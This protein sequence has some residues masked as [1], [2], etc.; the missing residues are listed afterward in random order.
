MIRSA[1]LAGLS[2]LVPCALAE[3][4]EAAKPADQTKPIVVP[5]EMLK[6]GHMAVKVKVN[7]KGPYRLIFDT[8]APMNLVNN[9][10]AR[11][12][13]LLKGQPKPTFTLFGAMGEAKIKS[14][15]VGGQKAEDV[16]CVVM[17]H[18]TVSMIAQKLG[19]ID[20]LVGF[21]FFARFK[22]T[23]DYQAKTMTFVPSGYK[24][25]DVMKSMM[26][27]LMVGT[28]AKVLAPLGQWGILGSKEVGDEDAGIDVKGVVPG[29]AADKAG[30]KRGDR[31]LTLD[32]RWTDSLEDLYDAAGSVPAGTTVSVTLKRKGKEMGLKVTPAPGM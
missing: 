5:F 15:E 6:S 8:G 24:P 16:P 30:L 9:K 3:V 17:D 29:S 21:P 1:F 14:L 2:L 27:L 25:P 19:P 31:L 23:L 32:S 7:G 22:M 4:P 11:D 20:G 10:I 12:A 28:T 13:D 26:S 18:P